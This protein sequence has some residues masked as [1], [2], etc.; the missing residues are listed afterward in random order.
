MTLT[1]F[2]ARDDTRAPAAR[3]EETGSAR[4][5]AT[6]ALLALAAGAAP[7]FSLGAAL[8]QPART[9]ERPISA[10]A[11]TIRPVEFVCRS[12]RSISVPSLSLVR[13]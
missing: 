13:Q 5:G 6:G 9:E 11:P 10:S 1:V 4:D 3:D 12:L 7:L 2:S 8:T